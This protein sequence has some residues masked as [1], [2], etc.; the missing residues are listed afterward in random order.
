[1][2]AFSFVRTLTNAGL[3]KPLRVESQMQGKFKD[4]IGFIGRC[5]KYAHEVDSLAKLFYNDYNVVLA[6]GK[7]NAMKNMIIRFKKEGYP[8]DGLGE[9]F[10]C[11]ITTSQ[12]SI[13]NG[14][15]D[16]AN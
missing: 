13:S 8:I 5:F 10:Q 2:K 11:R 1:M 14:F 9:Q 3:R 7:R 12:T 4:P 6:S 16:L 15:K